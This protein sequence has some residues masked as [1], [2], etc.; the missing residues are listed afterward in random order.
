MTFRLLPG[1]DRAA[2]AVALTDRLRSSGVA[3]AADAA[4]VFARALHLD[5]PRTRTGLYWAARLTLVDRQENLA[6]FDAVFDRVFEQE[7]LPMDPHARR[8]GP[9]DEKTGSAAPPSGAA[10]RPPRDGTGSGDLPWI[11]RTVVATADGPGGA[12]DRPGEAVPSALTGIADRRFADLDPVDLAAVETWIDQ[13]AV[14]WA[15]RRTRRRVRRHRG[16]LDVRASIGASRSTG[17]EPVRLVRTQPDRELRRVVMLCDVSRSM[18]PY[19]EVYLHLVRAL[20][21]TRAAEVFVFSTTVTRLTAVLRDRSAA[22]AI[23]TANDRVESRF[24]GTRIAASLAEVLA[25]R[26]GHLLRGAIVVIAS[27]GWDSDDPA[28]LAHV[29]ARIRRR[30]H[31]VVWLNPRAGQVGFVPSTGSMAAALPYCDALV[32]ADTLDSLHRAVG[33]VTS[34]GDRPGELRRG[35]VG[36][37]REVLPW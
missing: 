35:V 36:G 23:A 32:A 24:G 27:D 28:D 14:R 13:A 30:A 5:P 3:V 34:P 20:A 29:M 9:D 19:V 6:A 31:R 12:A 2:F 17:F 7:G 22:R 33:V 15:T 1:I 11:T 10:A 25:S 16:R 26:R 37:R 4:A 8:T 21:R 18:R